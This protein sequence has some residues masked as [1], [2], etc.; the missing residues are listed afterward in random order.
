MYGGREVH[1]AFWWRN[2]S[3]REHLEDPGI[4]ARIILR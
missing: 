3:I 2:L 1:T 4:D